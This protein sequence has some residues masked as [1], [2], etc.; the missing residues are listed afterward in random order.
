VYGSQFG[1][2]S[3]IPS[4]E[5][6]MGGPMKQDLIFT[7][8][9]LMGE[10]N[11]NHLVNDTP[12]YVTTGATTRIWGPIGFQFSAGES[13]ATMYTNAVN[14]IPGARNNFAGDAILVGAGYVPNPTSGGTARGNVEPFITG[15]GSGT[16]NVAWEV[17]SDPNKNFQYS[18]DGYQYWT[19]NNANGDATI[20]N[21]WPGTYRLSAYVLG[22]WGEL[23]LD[24][25]SVTAGSTTSL[26]G[27][28]F[29]PENFGPNGATPVWTI[30]TPDRSSH[31]FLHGENNSG[32]AGSCSGCDDREYFGNWNY[33]SDFAANSGS[34]VYFATAVGSTS[35]TNNTQKWNYTSSISRSVWL[36]WKP[37]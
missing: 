21:V 1:A 35:A 19:A 9:I 5:T 30:G 23:R 27:L 15:G 12:G 4:T 37:I 8:N 34:V 26:H 29:T 20:S 31:E 11:S 28:T 16:T 14:S 36:A 6:L 32:N 3:I 25:V 33:W 17:L 22:E 10:L 13:A 7:E 18:A 24:G 2:C